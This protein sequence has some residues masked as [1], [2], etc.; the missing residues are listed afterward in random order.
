[1]DPS[2]R[3]PRISTHASVG[4]RAFRRRKLTLQHRLCWCYINW[5]RQGDI[6]LVV[7]IPDSLTSFSD[8]RLEALLDEAAA[9]GDYLE[10]TRA[11]FDDM[12][13]EAAAA[14]ARKS[15]NR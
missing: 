8:R 9:S 5:E 2:E 3:S 13:R 12:E 1:V 10:A 11:D 6:I 15:R 14:L 4:S 7:S